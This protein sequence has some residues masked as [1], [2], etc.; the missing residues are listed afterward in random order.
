MEKINSEAISKA[1]KRIK[2]Y[3]VETPLVTRES[4]NK[5]FDAKI[6]F[7]LECNQKTGSFKI[8]GALNKILQL[9]EI[10]KKRGVIAYSSGNHG[11]AVSYASKL[12]G[13]SS[14]IVMPSDA[15]KIKIMKTKKY[16]AEIFFYDRFKESREGIAIELARKTKRV[17]IKPFDDNDI[18]IGQ[19]TVGLEIYKKLI[20]NNI[21]PDVMLCC[22]S[23]GGLIAGISTYLKNF[24]SR[25]SVY[26]V[27]PENYDDMRLSLEKGKLT[28]INPTLPTICD[29]LTV[30]IAGNLTFKINKKILLGGLTVSED[31]VIRAVNFLKKELNVVA[32]PGG[33]AA[34]AAFLSKYNDFKKKV[35]VIV[36]SGGNIDSDLLKKITDQNDR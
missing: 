10:Q 29:A 27:E 9:D 14:L 1:H 7:K 17:L 6:Y 16:G 8:R 34:V 12:Q 4:I 28:A 24:F 19:G 11:Q 3:I 5:K 35:V 33:A 20:K 23:G 22:C 21:K 36:V 13:I 15:P 26:S 2:K 31:D 18:I 25:L 32:E 30:N